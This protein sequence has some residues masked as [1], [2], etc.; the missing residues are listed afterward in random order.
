MKKRITFHNTIHL[1]C[2]KECKHCDFEQQHILG[3]QGKTATNKDNY[4]SRMTALYY[5]HISS[6]MACFCKLMAQNWH[7]KSPFVRAYSSFYLSSIQHF[8]LMLYTSF[9]KLKFEI[10]YLQVPVMGSIFSLQM[11]KPIGH[12]NLNQSSSAYSE[13]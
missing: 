7:K 11:N 8:K 10:I 9:N 13:N 3:K 4:I 5:C 12:Q 1:P 6:N 2:P